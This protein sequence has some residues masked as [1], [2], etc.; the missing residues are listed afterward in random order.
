MAPT[1][2]R[3]R[4]T[5][6]GGNTKFYG[7]ALFRLRQEDFGELKHHGGISPAW[8]IRTTTSSL[9]HA[10]PSGSITCTAARRGPDRS[11][12]SAPYPH[13]AVSHEPRIQQLADDFARSGLR[14]FHVPLGIMLDEQEPGRALHPLCDLR[15][16]SRA[17]C[18]RK[19]DAQVCA[20]IRARVSR[21]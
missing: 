4:T 5:A 7:A 13:P 16:P 11:A 14:P 2:I 3:T 10:R 6:S 12:A 21:T 18:R 20:S 19:A 8:P 15:R 17:S 9:L 1:S